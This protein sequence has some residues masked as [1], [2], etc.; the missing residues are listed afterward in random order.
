VPSRAV[1]EF[2]E[3]PL[4]DPRLGAVDAR[5]YVQFGK[6]ESAVASADMLLEAVLPYLGLPPGPQLG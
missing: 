1:F 6:A 5:D 3:Y 2:L 4:A